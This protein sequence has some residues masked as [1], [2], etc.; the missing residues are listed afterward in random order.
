M[1]FHDGQFSDADED[2]ESSRQPCRTLPNML[3]P[4]LEENWDMSDGEASRIQQQQQEQQQ[5]QQQQ[6]QENI[7]NISPVHQ[8]SFEEN[9]YE[10]SDYDYEEDAYCIDEDSK[11]L[12]KQ[13]HQTNHTSP[14]HSIT[15]SSKIEK[16]QPSEKLFK[17]YA[18]KICLEKFEG[19]TGFGGNVTNRLVETQKRTD[20]ERQRVRDKS[21]RATV[22]QVLDPRTRMILFKFLNKGTITEINGCIS[23]GK[24]A[25][26]YHALGS[27]GQDYAVKIY[28]TSILTFKDRD[29]YVSGD[30]RFRHGYGKHNPRKM[31]RTW[32]EKETSN[33]F[34][35]YNCGLPVPR[36]VVLRSHVLVMEFLGTNS[37]PSP[38]LKDAEI[39]E[40]KARELYYDLVIQMWVMYRQCHLVHADLS[41]FNLLYHQGRPFI[42]DVSQS[43][44]PDHPHSLDFLRKDCTNITEY[45]RKKGVPTMTV[46]ELFNFIVDQTVTSQNRDEYLEKMKTLASSRPVGEMTNQEQVDEEVFKNVFIPKT[47]DQVIDFERDFEQLKMGE[48]TVK[49]IPYHNVLGFKKDL[50]GP[51]VP[52]HLLPKDTSDSGSDA[53]EEDEE[54]EDEAD[55]EKGDRTTAGRPR[56][57]SP[58]SKKERKKAVRDAQAEKRKTKVKKHIKKKAEK[59][60]RK[61]H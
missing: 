55:L 60:K 33:L 32:A 6:Q 26:V 24:E 15:Q 28:K 19:L 17:K 39:S 51:E 34:R 7:K 16:F 1:E 3:I 44:T 41:E 40:N 11:D 53:S 29:R 12:T 27:D 8:D 46:H 50:T 38:R 13:Y 47:L 2:S 56:G 31:V 61:K 36:P 4:E 37:M 10:D 22:E 43:V 48:K 52:A 18:G 20:N 57:E 9:D 5:Q 42:I 14:N 35:M 49:D 45:F 30:H 25:N 54:S 59:D 58:S 21:E 23:T